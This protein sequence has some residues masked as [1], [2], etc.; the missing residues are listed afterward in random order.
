M[1][2]RKGAGGAG[3]ALK[4]SGPVDAGA[5]N[6]DTHRWRDTKRYLWPL[7]LLVPAGPFVAWLLAHTVSG[8]LWGFGGYL[9]LVVV[10]FLD[11]VCRPDRSGPPDEA[12]PALSADN[13]YR[14]CTHLFV[15]VQYA[16]LFFGFWCLAHE[17]MTTG[18][19]VGLCITMGM[20]AAIGINA[21]HELG[22]KRGT[23]EQT[24]AK[25]ALAPSWY[26]HFLVEHNVGHH[27]KVATAQDP[28]SARL[29]ESLWRFYPRALVGGFVSGVRLES[30]RLHR[31]G[32]RFWHWRNNI[33][34]S[35]A[36]SLV[37]VIVIVAV[38]GWG[39]APW[40]VLQ[41]VIGM[42]V[43][44][45]VNYIEHY[46]LL[47][48]PRAGGRPGKV[49]PEHSWNGDH[50]FSN[51]VLLNLQRHSDHHSRPRR[52]YQ[53]LRSCE[54]AP[55]FP[56]GYAL[57][58]LLATVPPLWRAVMDRRVMAHYGGDLSRVNVHP[59]KADAMARRYGHH[60]LATPGRDVR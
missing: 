32:L 1:G 46:G 8:L 43:L 47:R 12:V 25:L 54:E 41:A 4:R 11:L 2:G 51:V 36:A 27:L 14:W 29:G 22:H 57:M 59:A 24:L 49:H 33:A 52:R 50:V 31:R 9:L 56:A 26:G 7:S 10:P 55:Q 37:I 19:R 6:S 40:F 20:S 39:A 58:V 3:F 34:Q 38:F 13:Y 45:A 16:G 21:A 44:E 53:V 48:I 42:L 60:P 5:A 30:A 18:E 17:P 35:W 23:C 28:A 15:P